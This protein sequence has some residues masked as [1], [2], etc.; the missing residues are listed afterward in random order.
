MSELAP[1][2]LWWLSFAD[3]DL[4]PGRRFLGVCIVEARTLVSAVR[5]AARL[6]CNPGGEVRGDALPE[7]YGTVIGKQHRDVLLNADEARQL[8]GELARRFS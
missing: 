5:H 7:E 4:P 8:N 1:L 3:P 6:G 2:R